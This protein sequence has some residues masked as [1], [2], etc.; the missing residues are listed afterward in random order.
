[1]MGIE[2]TKEQIKVWSI[3]TTIA[4]GIGLVELLVISLF[5]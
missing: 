2:D 5:V 4:W 1:M 3:T